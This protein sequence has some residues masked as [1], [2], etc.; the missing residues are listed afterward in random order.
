MASVQL[1]N[2]LALSTAVSSEGEPYEDPSS[3][4]SALVAL[5]L[6]NATQLDDDEIV[7]FLSILQNISLRHYEYNV[8]NATAVRSWRLLGRTYC[9][10]NLQLPH[11][12]TIG[13]LWEKVTTMLV[14]LAADTLDSIESDMVQLPIRSSEEEVDVQQLAGKVRFLGFVAQRSTELLSTNALSLSSLQKLP[15]AAVLL[16]II[17]ALNLAASYGS[18]FDDLIVKTVEAAGDL[19]SAAKLEVSDL[20]D[21]IAYNHHRGYDLYIGTC[22]LLVHLTYCAI[23]DGTVDQCVGAGISPLVHALHCI[24]A[25]STGAQS[26]AYIEDIVREV[27]DALCTALAAVQDEEALFRCVVRLLS[28]SSH[29]GLS[30]RNLLF[31]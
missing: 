10:L 8:F 24:A 18:M 14:A 3:I 1:R 4:V 31:V 28:P 15:C 7:V 30:Y 11:H 23:V 22:K 19:F 26:D 27:V 29:G 25:E 16:R 13:I 12:H 17:G 21:I 20:T 5:E 2:L 6:L 9:N